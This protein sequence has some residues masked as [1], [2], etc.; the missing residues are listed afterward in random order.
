MYIDFLGDKGGARL[1]YG[2]KFTFWSAEDLKEV[3]P[4]Y[5]IPNMYHK[6]HVAFIDSIETGVKDKNHIDYVLESM[7]LLDAL[8]ESADKN[9]EITL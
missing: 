5:D 8:Y 4:E 9:K 7:K 2:G 1:D 3:K 6:E